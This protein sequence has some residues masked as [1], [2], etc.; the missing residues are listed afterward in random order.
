MATWPTVLPKWRIEYSAEYIN[1]V[2]RTS[3]SGIKSQRKIADRNAEIAA[4]SL[5]LYGAQLPV[6]EY[7]VQEVLNEGQDFFNADYIANG[8]VNTGLVRIVGGS[9][10][11][12]AVTG[13]DWQIDCQI[14]VTRA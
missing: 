6:F 3:F 14:E 2:A 7:F 9:Y 13:R 5:I 12:T 11:V 8:A 10:N 4:V 1:A